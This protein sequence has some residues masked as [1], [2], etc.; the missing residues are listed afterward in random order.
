MAPDDQTNNQ[1]GEPNISS[2]LANL[3]HDVSGTNA[4]AF[5]TL[6]DA[7]GTLADV[8]GGVIPVASFIG[9]ALKL[10]GSGPDELQ[11][12]EDAIK[13][14]FHQL[15]QDQRAS[16]LLTSLTNLQN[17]YSAAMTAG[18]SLQSLYKTLP[19]TSIEVVN[20]LKPIL[21][22]VNA[23]APPDVSKLGCANAG[24]GGPW[25]VVYDLQIF[26]GDN[27]SPDVTWPPSNSTTPSFPGVY[28]GYGAQDAPLPPE[29]NDGTVFN[30]TYVLPQWLQAVNAFLSIGAVIDPQFVA[31]WSSAIRSMA[32]LLQSVH[33]YILNQGIVSLSPGPWNEQILNSWFTRP[34]PGWGNVPLAPPSSHA[35][36]FP[37][38]SSE[39]L[40]S[41]TPTI[42]GARIEYGAVETF[43]GCSS[44]AMYQ[45]SFPA[46]NLLTTDPKPYYKFQIRLLQKWKQVYIGCGLPA[47][48]QM[49]NNLKSLVGDPPLPRP[50]PADWS[51]RQLAAIAAGQPAI[52]HN[53][54]PVSLVAIAR[55]VQS[56]LPFDAPAPPTGLLYVSFRSL[57]E[58]AS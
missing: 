6:G 20:Q 47:A 11:Q 38:L 15:Q 52:P 31:N 17:Q 45:L 25:G 49:I 9:V 33:D 50:S 19:L 42:V 16:N 29:H 57:L 40:P 46:P 34:I 51:M 10:I 26:W 4:K 55:F 8:V 48:W 54:A 12:I 58:P 41:I 30:Y 14:L 7:I 37:L 22:S 35:G 28:W 21:D 56:T 18:E 13:N 1:K 27:D 23:L 5:Q 43:S 32:C 44:V 53:P 3:L 39:L 2:N 24:L 36:V